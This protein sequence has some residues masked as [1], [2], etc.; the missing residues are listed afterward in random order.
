MATFTILYNNCNGG[1]AFS[2]AFLAEYTK[3]TSVTL[4]TFK[5]LFRQGVESI[6]CDP[7][8]VAIFKEKG[9]EWCSGPNSQIE[10][11][12][13]PVAMAKYWEIDEYYGDEHVR[14]LTAEA[15][16]DILHTYMQTGD[17]AALERQYSV[18]MGKAESPSPNLGPN[19]SYWGC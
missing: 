13:C 7:H 11:F 6:R 16:A 5:A 3:R 18:I 12:E 4:D 17:R 9:S 2:D 14:M 8:A 1:F 10:A 15:L 19:V